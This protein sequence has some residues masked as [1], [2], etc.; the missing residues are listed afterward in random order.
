M[1]LCVLPEGAPCVLPEGAG[2]SVAAS[3]TRRIVTFVMPKALTHSP[4]RSWK[5]AATVAI[6][7]TLGVVL[8]TGVATAAP[9]FAGSE[10]RAASVGA[11]TF[12][13]N[14]TDAEPALAQART[15]LSDAATAVFDAKNSDVS[16]GD[17][18]TEIDTA[19]LEETI[20]TLEN[21]DSPSVL[22]LPALMVTIS[23]QTQQ[24]A[25]QTT[26]LR[27]SLDAAIEKR[28]A[29]EEKKAAEKAA[30]KAAAQAAAARAA[31]NTPD[32][33]KAA[34]QQIAA[35]KYGWGGDQ[36]SCLSSL[37]QKESNWD[38]QAYNASSGAT[39]IPQ[40]L[41]GSKM[42]SAGADWQTNAVTQ[43]HWGLDYIQ[44]AYGAPCAAWSHSQSVN[45]Y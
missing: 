8:T 1:G 6:T 27:S 34:A 3:T 29:E 41:P 12:T 35:E 37:W 38:Y 17:T 45:W 26:S 21:A 22:L 9:A 4:T 32:G 40:A 28:A 44:R 33:A 43:I 42:A 36:F 16:L 24:V 25:A 11:T 23:E 7:A 15:T 31:S 19:A 13:V 14:P 2:C 39:G 20:T 18:S 30:A 10:T 5:T